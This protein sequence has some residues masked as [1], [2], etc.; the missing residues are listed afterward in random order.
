M[1]AGTF[2]FREHIFHTNPDRVGKALSPYLPPQKTG[3]WQSAVGWLYEQSRDETD[4]AIPL[5]APGEQWG[6]AF[7]GR[8]DNREQLINTFNLPTHCDDAE[9]L[10]AGWEQ[11]AEQLPQHLIGDFTLAVLD[12]RSHLLFLARD[13][14]GVKPLYYRF[15]ELGMVFGSSVPAINAIHPQRPTPDTEWMVRYLWGLSFQP[16]TT[17]YTE[18][19]K[20]P[21]GHSLTLTL[22]GR[23]QLNH[24]HR[25]RDDAPLATRRDPY[26]VDEYRA[27][28]EESIRC[29]MRACERFGSESSG[30]IDSSTITAY[31]AKCLPFPAEQLCCFG[32]TLS[33]LEAE[34]ILETSRYCGVAHNHLVTTLNYLETSVL[35]RTFH[36]LGYPDEHAN[37]VLH[38]PFYRECVLHGINR[39]FS[40][41][42][43]DEVVTN[44]GNLL[45]YELLDEGLYAA[46]WDITPGHYL[47]RP[48]RFAKR[49]LIRKNPAFH[50]ALLSAFQQRW[51]DCIIRAEVAERFGIRQRYMDNARFDAP[52][53]RINDFILKHHLHT[54]Q[55]S[56]R[57]ENCTLVAASY[58]IDYCWPLWDVRLVQQYLSTPAIEKVGPHG[59]GR[60][61][62]RRAIDGTVPSKVAWKPTKNMGNVVTE[63]VSAWRHGQPDELLDL[64]PRLVELIDLPKWHKQVD[65][66]TRRDAVIDD[67]QAFSLKRNVNAVRRLNLWLRSL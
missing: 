41:F 24:W 16:Q 32:F 52:F 15:D 17:A 42:G 58:G 55:L 60:Y 9:L 56:A 25:W 49:L 63:S 22:H 44:P 11:W 3:Y 5:L 4:A 1:F 61:L 13:P 14:I 28:L 27:T 29:R 31:L 51:P 34:Y 40:G 33:E 64:D 46:L 38:I 23:P 43:G 45:P 8:L 35:E 53:R 57:L 12:T 47:S 10:L 30:G 39:L 37:A 18:I 6:I 20:L 19:Q 62:H 66:L 26:W 67:V 21:P 50:A 7:W 48:L 2:P 65:S 36:V 59:I 54:M